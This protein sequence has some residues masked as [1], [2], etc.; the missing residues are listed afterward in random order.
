M[1]FFIPLRS[2]KEVPERGLKVVMKKGR[3]SGWHA[4]GN[5]RK[6]IG[7]QTFTNITLITERRIPWFFPNKNE[8]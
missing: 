2:E 4:L 5:A 7:N 6:H 1:K 3:E 8:V